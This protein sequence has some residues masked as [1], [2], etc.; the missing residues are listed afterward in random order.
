MKYTFFK[1][2]IPRFNHKTSGLKGFRLLVQAARAITPDVT[3]GT[4]NSEE[5]GKTLFF[6]SFVNCIVAI[7]SQ[8]FVIQGHYSDTL[9]DRL[10]CYK[11]NRGR[12]YR[13]LATLPLHH[14]FCVGSL[15]WENG[16]I[17]M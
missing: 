6:A 16:S 5:M 11:S 13:D 12:F 15:Y 8:R 7:L 10:N 2:F 3:S 4:V 1:F 14:L 9:P 17:N